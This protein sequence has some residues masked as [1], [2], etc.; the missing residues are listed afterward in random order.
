MARR[1]GEE[2]GLSV[3][4][5]RDRQYFRSVYFR[6]P[7]GVLFE[8]ATDAPGFAVDEPL[9][10][11]GEAL[12]LPAGLEQH[13]AAIEG[14]AAQGAVTHSGGWGAAH[15]LDRSKIDHERH[16]ARPGAPLRTRPARPARQCCCSTA[17]AATKTDLLPLGRAGGAG[18]RAAVA[19]RRRAGETGM[20][21][22]FRRMAEGVFDEE[23]LRRR[24][25]DLAA[26]VAAAR[27]ALRPR[28]PPGARLLQWRQYRGGG[29]CC[30]IP[31]RWAGA[32]LL[33]PHG[34][35]RRAAR[36]GP[37]RP[38]GD[39]PVGRCRSDRSCRERRPVGGATRRGRRRCGPPDRGGRPWV[40]TGRCGAR[41]GGGWRHA[42]PG[43]RGDARFGQQPDP[44][45][46]PKARR[47]KT[48]CLQDAL[49]PCGDRGITAAP[50]AGTPT[51][52][53]RLAAPCPS[54]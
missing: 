53:R 14:R 25:Q 27:G 47:R 19:A 1:L 43:R 9:E 8:I 18:V 50:T 40:V 23:D 35:A 44:H 21:R 49:S 39:D 46:S 7:G 11:L 38:A 30:C 28:G 3:T 26:F 6:E 48:V 17:P 32:L 2:H 36:C 51:P 41:P 10:A 16:T 37:R 42:D 52:R 34:A 31:R 5:Q 22:F 45:R 54:L 33:R 12:K 20:P 15:R 29:S 13:R 24:A 4:E